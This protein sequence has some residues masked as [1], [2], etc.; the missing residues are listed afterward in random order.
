[1]SMD[2]HSDGANV[3]GSEP[4]QVKATQ[5][6]RS[7]CVYMVHGYGHTAKHLKYARGRGASDTNLMTR[8]KIDPKVPQ[9]G[10]AADDRPTR[11]PARWRWA[12]HSATRQAVSP[13]AGWAAPGRAMR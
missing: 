2:L 12:A 5:R 10:P 1:M 9:L 4:V 6:I 11:R 8:V 7:D 3:F 13:V